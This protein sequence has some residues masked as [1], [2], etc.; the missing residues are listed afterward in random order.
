MIADLSDSANS[1][2]NSNMT[3]DLSAEGRGW[4]AGQLGTVHYDGSESNP[5]MDQKTNLYT[6]A[7]G[8]D[9]TVAEKYRVGIMVGY[10]RSELST[11][12]LYSDIYANSF[13]NSSTGGY[14][15]LH[16]YT[17]LGIFDIDGG[18]SVGFQSHDDSRFVNDNLKWWGISYATSKYNSQWVS[19]SIKLGVPMDLGSDWTFS[20]NAQLAYTYEH[21][22]SYSETGSNSNASYASQ[23]IGVLES[24]LA[25]DLSKSIGPL[26]GTITAGY[27][28]RNVESG[29]T[30]DVTMIG[31]THSVQSFAQSLSAGFAKANVRWDVSDKF[32]FNLAGTYMKGSRSGND[33]GN[34]SISLLYKF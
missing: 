11:G 20:P 6:V 33:G 13:K 28:N 8:Y 16:G 22:D 7:A 3:K 12:S 31:D 30:V 26:K 9:Q 25:L 10:N 19:P 5:T 32:A 2:I 23:G 15:S 27:L 24:K 18:L 1:L 4:V 14:T 17:K 29:D 21:V 34:G